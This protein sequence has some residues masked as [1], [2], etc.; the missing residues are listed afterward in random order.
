MF[1]REI[2]YINENGIIATANMLRGTIPEIEKNLKE[3]AP[4]VEIIDNEGWTCTET[5]LEDSFG[6]VSFILKYYPEYISAPD[7]DKVAWLVYLYYVKRNVLGEHNTWKDLKVL[8]E[9]SLDK[10]GEVLKFVEDEIYEPLCKYKIGIEP[11][12][13]TPGENPFYNGVKYGNSLMG[14]RFKDISK[15]DEQVIR[16]FLII[17]NPSFD[18]EVDVPVCSDFMIKRDA[19][20]EA[21]LYEKADWE[22]NKKITGDFVELI[23]SIF[24]AKYPLI[25]STIDLS[26]AKTF[27]YNRGIG[28]YEVFRLIKCIFEQPT[29]FILYNWYLMDKKDEE[30]LNLFLRISWVI[31]RYTCQY[32]FRER[33]EY[34][35][36]EVA[37]KNLP[38]KSD[39]VDIILREYGYTY[40]QRKK[41]YEIVQEFGTYTENGFK[42]AQNQ[43]EVLLDELKRKANQL[44]DE[45]VSAILVNG[46]DSIRMLQSNSKILAF[47][48]LPF[49]FFE[50]NVGYDEHRRAIPGSKQ[51]TFL[52]DFEAFD[53]VGTVYLFV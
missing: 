46:K 2:R 52:K 36:N 8:I 33:I 50:I 27:L 25:D 15:K 39:S 45:D 22:Y 48:F 44:S 20:Y 43:I 34:F 5:V 42:A 10:S 32:S 38:F 28:W 26:D 47:P 18:D 51:Y 29:A 21:L 7:F 12:A 49:D 16:K 6:A 9:C 1:E 31:Q 24:K 11:L 17:A 35:F 4:R 23:Q 19:L 3:Y 13:R 30:R 14:T 53:E 41:P 37:F 40:I